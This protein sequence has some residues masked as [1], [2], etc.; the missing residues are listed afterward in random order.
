MEAMAQKQPEQ[1]MLADFIE[2]IKIVLDTLPVGTEISISV[3]ETD[4]TKF[5]GLRK[6][7][8]ELKEIDNK[9]TAFEIGSVTKAFTGNIL[10]KLVTD[11][12]I[13]LDDPI[14]SFI[15]FK[16]YGSPVISFRQ[17]ALHISGLPRMPPGYDDRENFIEENPFCNFEEDDLMIYLGQNLV[18]E[19]KPGLKV[20]YSNLGFALLSYIFSKI[21]KKP[22]SKIVEE[23][24]LKPLDM[25]DTS[26]DL[27][28]IST[29]FC[30]GLDK[31]GN[32][33]S[34]WNGGIFNGSLGLIS[35]A[36][37]LSKFAKMSLNF[38]DQAIATQIQNTFPAKPGVKTCL[39]WLL[40]NFDSEEPIL[41]INGGTA[42]S[43]SSVFLNQRKQTAF[44]FCSNIHPDTYMKSIEH[45]CIEA[46]T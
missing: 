13:S 41:K 2:K 9:A 29:L 24:I 19:S 37:D 10:A 30:P 7:P 4:K 44:T 5:L 25:K 34:C 36:E 32:Q 33:T 3:T 21:E 28:N 18:M 1:V 6:N 31:D 38:E 15:P 26:F 17:L 16:L 35:T 40:V 43:S 14:D 12:K 22:F 42:G 8:L 11:L 39:G 20:S 45:L 27:V 23:R 46:V